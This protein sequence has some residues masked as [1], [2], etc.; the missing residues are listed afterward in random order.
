MMEFDED[1]LPVLTEVQKLQQELQ[2][3]QEML[4]AK[5]QEIRDLTKEVERL[6]ERNEKLWIKIEAYKEIVMEI[7]G[8]NI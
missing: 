3:K 7:M 6:K 8:G 5:N 1:G 4:D 2:I